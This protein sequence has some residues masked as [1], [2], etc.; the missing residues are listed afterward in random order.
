MKLLRILC[1]V[2]LTAGVASANN[3]GGPNAPDYR[4]DENSVLAVFENG[5]PS[6]EPT[7]WH[8]ALIEAGPSIYTLSTVQP[9]VF[10]DDIITEITLPNFI[11]ELPQFNTNTFILKNS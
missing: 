3:I 10:G 6:V 7:E 8:V 4:Y 5:F 9:E 2:L 1:I 11:D